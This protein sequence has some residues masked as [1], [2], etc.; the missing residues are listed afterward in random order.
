MKQITIGRV[1]WCKFDFGWIGPNGEDPGFFL[2]MKLDSLSSPTG[3]IPAR[4][5]AWS[6]GIVMLFCAIALAVVSKAEAADNHSLLFTWPEVTVKTDGTD[7]P[8][9]ERAGYLVYIGSAAPVKALTPSFLLRAPD[10][11]T[12]P[13]GTPIGFQTVNSKDKKST[14]STYTLPVDLVG[15][16]CKGNSWTH[17]KGVAYCKQWI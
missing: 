7:Y 12:I 6:V 8:V 14:I 3:D 11:K 17:Y 4:S 16:V 13:A 1:T 2:K 5:V 9:N 15:R 10:Q